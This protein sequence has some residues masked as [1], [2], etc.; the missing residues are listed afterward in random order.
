VKVIVAMAVSLLTVACHQTRAERGAT[1]DEA[2]A[3]ASMEPAD[4]EEGFPIPRGARRN[5]ALGGATTL[6]PGQNYVIRVYD[7]DAGLDAAIAFYGRHL[8]DARRSAAGE[9]VRFS[10]TGG[11]VTLVRS[12]QGVR[13]TLALGPQ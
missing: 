11:H 1:M 12:A 7:V 4:W 6:P 13:I 2:V 3:A 5:R 9:G 8:P 10:K